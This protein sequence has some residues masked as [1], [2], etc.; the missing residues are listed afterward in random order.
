MLSLQIPAQGETEAQGHLGNLWSSRLSVQAPP[1]L[2]TDNS[3][4]GRRAR[5]FSLKLEGG[6]TKSGQ[7][8]S[9]DQDGGRRSPGDHRS[10]KGLL[11][12]TSPVSLAL[13]Q[14]AE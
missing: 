5:G 1:I 14:A 11:P 10:R 7:V 8:G 2:G 9:D 4:G 13:S 12:T 6:S 3:G